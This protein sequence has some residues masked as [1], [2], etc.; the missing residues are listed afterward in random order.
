MWYVVG[1]VKGV[2]HG[3]RGGRKC[4]GCDGQSGG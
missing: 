3:R 1:I 2:E 4:G